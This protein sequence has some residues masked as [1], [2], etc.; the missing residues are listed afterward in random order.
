MGKYLSIRIERLSRKTQ[1]AQEEAHDMIE[2]EKERKKNPRERERNPF[3][4][5]AHTLNRKKE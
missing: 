3:V 1:R 2:R 5:K 4:Q